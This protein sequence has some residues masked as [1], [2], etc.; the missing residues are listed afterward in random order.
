VRPFGLAFGTVCIPWG[1]IVS[2]RRREYHFF[3][4][5]EVCYGSGSGAILGFL[6]SAAARSI[7]ERLDTTAFVVDSE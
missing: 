7:A 4:V 5:L 6:P 1:Q 3:T 2:A